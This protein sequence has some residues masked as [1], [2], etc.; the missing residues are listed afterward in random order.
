MMQRIK[1]GLLYALTREVT[2]FAVTMGICY[3]LCLGLTPRATPQWV[4]LFLVVFLLRVNLI[5]T[6]VTFGCTFFLFNWVAPV[7]HGIGTLVLV[8]TPALHSFF[9]LLYHAPF[10][11]Y[12]QFN[13]TV[14]MG[15]F[16]SL[17][18]LVPLVFVSSHFVLK[19]FRSRIRE[20]IIKNYFWRMLNTQHFERRAR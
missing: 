10:F 4:S 20:I 8:K 18:I 13:N 1:S 5:A 6:F 19:I 14:V 15:S 9:R 16:L 2:N 17:L 7:F 11:P 12:L 3:G